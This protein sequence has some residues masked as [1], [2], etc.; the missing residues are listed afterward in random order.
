MAGTDILEVGGKGRGRST[1]WKWG[2]V[3]R[4]GEGKGV[5]IEM[6]GRRLGWV[7][8]AVGGGGREEGGREMEG[9]DGESKLYLFLPRTK[10]IIT[11]ASPINNL[12]PHS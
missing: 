12:A 2:G 3:G 11:T 1:P 7:L 4:K 5:G 9:R 8:P 6:G 10:D